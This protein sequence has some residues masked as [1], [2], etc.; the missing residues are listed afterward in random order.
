MPCAAGLSDAQAAEAVRARIDW[1]Y[2]LALE[3]TDP[4]FD[5]AVLRAC[6]HRLITGHAELLVWE[7]MLARLRAQGLRNAN[8][9][10]RTDSPPVLAARQ[11]LHRLA[12]LGEILRHARHGLATVAPDWLQAWV[13]AVW[14][15]RD[16]QR[17]AD[18]RLPPDNPAREA[19]AERRG[20][21]GRPRLWPLDEP[22]TLGSSRATRAPLTSRCAGARRRIR[23]GPGG[24]LRH[25]AR[26]GR[27]GRQG[28]W[29]R[30]L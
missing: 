24:P 17:L 23:R 5:V 6:R 22:A 15:D 16:R 19:L 30:N 13:P 8:G 11:T 3:L 7:T 2:A 4:G 1:P 28:A 25:K 9:R 18:D 14:F 26:D 20:T 12:C 27:D 10:Q 21:A 29:H